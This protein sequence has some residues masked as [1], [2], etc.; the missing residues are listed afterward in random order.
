MQLLYLAI[1]L[2]T[3]IA[4]GMSLQWRRNK[5][6]ITRLEDMREDAYDEMKQQ[7][8]C[9]HRMAYYQQRIREL[10]GGDS[11][12]DEDTFDMDEAMMQAGAHE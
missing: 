8:W 2:I 9:C 4:F 7:K 11:D 5:P 12:W 3:G 6:Y 10:T 1:A